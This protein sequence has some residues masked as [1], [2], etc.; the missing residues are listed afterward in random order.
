MAQVAAADSAWGVAARMSDIDIDAIEARHRDQVAIGVPTRDDGTLDSGVQT[1]IEDVGTVLGALRAAEAREARRLWE[2]VRALP[3]HAF[4][5]GP[6]GNPYFEA[7]DVVS[8]FCTCRLPFLESLGEHAPYCTVAPTKPEA[9][10]YSTQY[11]NEGRPTKPEA[12]R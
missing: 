7:A 3:L 5:G 11:V 9:K 4:A 1:W 10:A 2:R 6:D 8:L 12:K